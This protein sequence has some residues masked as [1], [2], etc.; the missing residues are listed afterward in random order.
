MNKLR[1]KREEIAYANKIF[2]KRLDIITIVKS[3][4]FENKF[5]NYY[6]NRRINFYS[7]SSLK[8]HL[9]N[10]Y[11]MLEIGTS[12]FPNFI[13][14]LNMD[15]PK[16]NYDVTA[17][18]ISDAEIKKHKEF[19]QKSNL[20][21]VLTAKF[22]KRNAEILDFNEDIKFDIVIGGAILH[23][24]N[25]EKT[26]IDL[27][28]WLDKDSILVFREPLAHNP[29]F[30]LYRFFTPFLHTEDEEPINLYDFIK[31][32]KKSNYKLEI[33]YQEALSPFLFPFNMISKLIRIKKFAKF[34][35]FLDYKFSNFYF[36]KP[37]SRIATFILVPIYK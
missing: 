28:N 14:V 3:F 24:I 33:V 35:S 21:N 32:V 12:W 29:I 18:N 25:Y 20:N 17:I 37:L 6:S 2:T 16:N 34:L 26:L 36:L 7:Y 30:N 22:E 27:K 10:N 31:I 5:T 4:L 11:K 8:K 19:F 1:E 23:H 9:N 13:R 15:F